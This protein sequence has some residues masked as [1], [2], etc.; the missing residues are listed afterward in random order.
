MYL[1][2]AY[3]KHSLGGA[4]SMQDSDTPYN[5]GKLDKATEFK[6]LYG[7]VYRGRIHYD[8]KSVPRTKPGR[9]DSDD[10]FCMSCSDKIALWNHV[11]ICGSLMGLLIPPI[12]LHGIIISQPESELCTNALTRRTL[13]TC[14]TFVDFVDNTFRFCKQKDTKSCPVSIVWNSHSSTEVLVNGIKQ[15][16]KRQHTIHEKVRS[17]VCRLKMFTL[18]KNVIERLPFNMNLSSTLGYE[19]WK[20]MNME[21]R[22]A[23]KRVYYDLKGWLIKR[24]ED[25]IYISLYE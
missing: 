4:A 24:N 22:E 1:S 2:T 7:T 5:A 8:K 3:S 10:T 19:A 17:N 9:L 14:N 12:F 20:K 23:K 21:Y 6:T 13:N 18:F 11:G 25:Y 15:G 16:A